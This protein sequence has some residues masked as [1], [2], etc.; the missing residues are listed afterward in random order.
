MHPV[1]PRWHRREVSHFGFRIFDWVNSIRQ[2]LIE[3]GNFGIE[4]LFAWKS[5]A[6]NGDRFLDILKIVLLEFFD[7][8]DERR[9][10]LANSVRKFARFD[11]RP[12]GLEP[13]ERRLGCLD[14]EI[15]VY[16]ERLFVFVAS[17][18]MRSRKFLAFRFM[19]LARGERFFQFRSTPA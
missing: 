9:A 4:F 6:E 7:P 3:D 5:I 10:Q 17:R 18:I 12:F 8:L 11:L 1:L 13:L 15:E 2:F 14:G 16:V 19:L